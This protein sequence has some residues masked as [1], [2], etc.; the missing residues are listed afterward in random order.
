MSLKARGSGNYESPCSMNSVVDD[1]SGLGEW[2]AISAISLV[3][4]DQGRTRRQ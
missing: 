3:D 2:K 4:V 1:T